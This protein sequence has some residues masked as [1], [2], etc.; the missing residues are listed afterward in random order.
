M[1]V[2]NGPF[3]EDCDSRCALIE[4]KAAHRG[5]V[6]ACIIG[7]QAFNPQRSG[8]DISSAFITWRSTDERR[9]KKA[10]TLNK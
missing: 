6:Y 4:T 9:T 1:H 10:L 2:P 5:L 3:A 7:G 8:N